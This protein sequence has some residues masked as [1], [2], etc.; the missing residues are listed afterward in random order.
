MSSSQ[1]T[2]PVDANNRAKEG[3][4]RPAKENPLMSIIFNIALPLIILQ[5]LSRRL[6]DEGPMIALVVALAIPF[7]YGLV[8][9]IKRKHKNYISL[10]GIINI[11]MTGGLALFETEGFWF[12]IKEAAFPLVIGVG[13]FCS[14]FTKRPF[15]E[16]MAYNENFMNV[17]RIEARLQK[18]GTKPE[19][20][21]HLRRSTF[22]LSFSFLLSSVLNFLL[23]SWIFT[24]IDSSLPEIERRALLNEQIADMTWLG[25]VVIAIPL[26]VFTIFVMWHL[27]N[28]I[29]KYSKL[30]LNEILPHQ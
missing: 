7:G 19:F 29:K 21:N 4:K 15:M 17:D 27:I 30:S 6:G 20:E 22:F 26:M 10:L 28:G 8:D 5:Q 2:N 16:L 9:Y 25:Y 14:A 18:L 11:L 3:S 23:A 24:E 13:V 12:T 1:N